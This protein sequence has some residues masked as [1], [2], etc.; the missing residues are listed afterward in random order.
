M[1]PDLESSVQVVGEA[2][3]ES[4]YY[5]DAERWTFVFWDQ[6]HAF[7]RRF[8]RL[9]LGH[10]VELACGQGRHS[11]IVAPLASRLTLMDIHQENLDVCRR[12]L[13]DFEN[14]QLLC[15]N[16][17][18][19]MPIESGSVTSVFCY[20]AMVH[21]SPD[22]VDSYLRDTFRILVPGGLGLFHHSNYDADPSKHYGLNP[23]AR[24]RMTMGLFNELAVDAG[25]EVV[26]STVLDWG[27]VRELDGLTL[28]RR[29]S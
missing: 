15:T 21:F 13:A 7:R 23:H 24:N 6:N 4:D 29:L 26:D 25:L 22:L 17:Y 20:D 8:D 10:V 16:G 11:A 1:A 12:R 2:W 5:A 28:V 3:K 27:G 19:Y 9:D 18:D 14:V